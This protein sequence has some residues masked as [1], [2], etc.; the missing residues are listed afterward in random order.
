MKTKIELEGKHLETEGH[1]RT[2]RRKENGE[3]NGEHRRIKKTRVCG[4][5]LNSS[6]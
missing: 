1:F 5:P 2:E 6:R 3:Q 4:F